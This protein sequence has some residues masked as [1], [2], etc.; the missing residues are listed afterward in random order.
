MISLTGIPKDLSSQQLGNKP[1]DP[2]QIQ[3]M[4]SSTL[5]MQRFRDVLTAMIHNSNQA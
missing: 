2:A 5:E 4:F 3:D 1:V